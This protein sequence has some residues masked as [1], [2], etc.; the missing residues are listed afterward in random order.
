MVGVSFRISKS[1]GYPLK[2]ILDCFEIRNYQWYVIDSQSDCWDGGMEKLLFCDSQYNGES[3]SDIIQEEHFV[4][5][6]KLEAYE[7]TDTH[8][9]IITADDFEASGCDILLL[10]YDCT[11]VEV[12]LKNE[13]LLNKFCKKIRSRDVYDIKNITHITRHELRIK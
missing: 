10:L 9:E 12:Y 7:K 8:V 13:N 5:S 6:L 11:F 1:R 3:L 2:E 4:I